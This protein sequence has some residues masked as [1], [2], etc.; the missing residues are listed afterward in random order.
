MLTF[1][2]SEAIRFPKAL[3]C[4]PVAKRIKFYTCQFSQ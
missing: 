3:A 2:D 1:I 4:V